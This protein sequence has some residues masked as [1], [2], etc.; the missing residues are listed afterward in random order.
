[1]HI[2]QIH[3][4]KVSTKDNEA[5][6]SEA[7]II[8]GLGFDSD[9]DDDVDFNYSDYTDYPSLSH[10][11]KSPDLSKNTSTSETSKSNKTEMIIEMTT[12]EAQINRQE[13]FEKYVG[14]YH[15]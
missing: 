13:E 5:D 10:S 9:Y 8:D 11:S 6:P 1:M 14:E 3:G 4:D 15:K 12:S 7:D 2:L